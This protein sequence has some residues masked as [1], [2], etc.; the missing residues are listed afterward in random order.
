MMESLQTMHRILVLNAKGGCGKTT[1]ATNLAGYYASQ[2][3]NTVLL[4]YDP[5]GSSMRWLSLRDDER[6]SIHGIAAFQRRRDITRAYQMRLPSTAEIVIMDAPAGVSG[7]TL[8]E[9]VQKVDTI[10]L[11][12]LPSPIDIHAAAH[13]VQDLL[14]VGKARAVGTRIAIVANRV[15]QNNLVYKDLERFLSSLNLPL[16]ATLRDSQ[17][18]IRAAEYGVGVHELDTRTIDSDIERWT[19]LISWLDETGLMV[20]HRNTHTVIPIATGYPG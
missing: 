18:H 20:D 7:L 9:Y 13:F 1:V 14:L 19:P 17:N 16:V 5:Q 15:R 11:P 6:P 2:G 4:D 8:A 12:V 3:R 10:L